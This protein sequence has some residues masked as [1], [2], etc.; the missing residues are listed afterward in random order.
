MQRAACVQRTGGE[1]LPEGGAW[2]GLWHSVQRA[3]ARGRAAARAA[4]RLERCLKFWF[5]LAAPAYAPLLPSPTARPQPT[6]QAFGQ[7]VTPTRLLTYL[8]PALADEIEDTRKWYD[9]G[10]KVFQ[11]NKWRK[12]ACEK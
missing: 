4:V 1:L 6:P 5:V 10:A 7:C 11:A 3:H 9:R 2:P 8:S 12:G